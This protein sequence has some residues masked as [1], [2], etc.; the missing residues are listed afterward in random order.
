MAGTRV[1]TERITNQGLSRERV[2]RLSGITRLP[3]SARV[4][5]SFLA[6]ALH[7]DTLP[8]GV[9]GLILGRVLVAV[10]ALI[11]GFFFNSAYIVGIM[12]LFNQK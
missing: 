3:A 8:M 4:L 11:C 6:L 12:E 10:V 1:Q 5:T 2:N 7:L 9:Q